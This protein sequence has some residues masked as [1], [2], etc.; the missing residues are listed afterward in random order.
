MV[1]FQLNDSSSF[2]LVYGTF[3]YFFSHKMVRLIL[4]TAPI[5]SAFG[6]IAA[7]RTFAWCISVWNEQKQSEEEVVPMASRVE[8]PNGKLSKEKKKKA[9]KK[10]ADKSSFEGIAVLKEALKV[11]SNSSEGV[12]AKRS[13]SVVLLLLM[14]FG[15][16]SFTNYCWQMSLGLSNPTIIQ[17]GRTQSGQLIEVDDYREAYWWLRHNTPEDSR[18]MAW[19]DYG[20]QITGIANRT[21]IADGNTWNH[22][23]IALLGKAL[24]TDVDTGYEIARHIADYVLVWGGGGG[25]DLAKSPHLARIANSVYRDH[26]P[27]DPTC[28]EFGFIDR[29]GTPSPMMGRSFLYKLHGHKIKPGVEAPADKFQE[30]YRSKYGKVRIYKLLG[31]SDES[32]KWVAD[33]SNRLCDVPG[34]WFCPGQYPPGLER[35]LNSKK[36]FAQLEDF[37]RKSADDEYQ[38]QYF[39]NLNSPEKAKQRAREKEMAEERAKQQAPQQQSQTQES[40]SAPSPD[41]ATT[42]GSP[43]KLVEDKQKR[44]YNNWQNGEE[45]TQMWKLIDSNNIEELK[46][47]MAEDPSIVFVRSEDGRGPMWWAFEN[48]R[49]EIVKILMDAGVPHT[50]KDSKGQGPIDLLE[51]QGM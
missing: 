25:D 6:G 5:S 9:S 23:H 32:K 13:V 46:A 34:S 27:G 41:V 51:G 4:L 40:S 10:V 20:Y 48:R 45:S 43:V 37:N 35:F 22:E 8:K 14:Y 19:W 21:T 11:A 36:D 38:K 28:R 15:S 3:A 33:Q 29:E 50:D 17:K 1:M 31:V 47:W 49:Q 24:T 16:K 42:T 44:R 39:E 7:G 26:C 18:I 30:V 12:L 2:L